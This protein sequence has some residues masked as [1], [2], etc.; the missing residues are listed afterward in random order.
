MIEMNGKRRAFLGMLAALA[1][2]LLLP[3][4]AFAVTWRSLAFEATQLS[5]AEKA[6][7][8]STMTTSQ[9]IEI[10]APEKAENGAIVQLEIT[11]RVSNTESILVFVEKNPTSLIAQYHFGVGALPRLVT[12]I[13]MADTSE[14]KV[15]VKAEGQ[16]L[17]AI[18]KVIVLENGCG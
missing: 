3:L 17:S 6:L 15:I 13:K 7:G 11:S 1:S 8:I 12:R 4:K 5:E 14:I 18:K 16:Y 9:L 2:M 10:V